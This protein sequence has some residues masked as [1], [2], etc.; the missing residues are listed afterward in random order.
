MTVSF[1][2]NF[3]RPPSLTSELDYELPSS[4]EDEQPVIEPLTFVN[5]S[6]PIKMNQPVRKLVTAHGMKN[7]QEGRKTPE[8]CYSQITVKN[9]LHAD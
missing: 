6:K 8:E 5:I 1:S 4:K 9:E 3:P 2:I 7:L